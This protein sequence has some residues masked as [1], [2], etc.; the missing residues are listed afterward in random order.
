M[1]LDVHAHLYPPEYREGLRARGGASLPIAERLTRMAARDRFMDGAIDE[2]LEMMDSLGVHRQV[3]SMPNQWVLIAEPE[4]CSVHAKLAN[5]ALSEVCQ[6]YPERFRMFASLPL[7]DPAAALAELERSVT[8]HGSLGIIMPTHILGKPL[9]W[10]GLEPIWA[11]MERRQLPVF[12]HPAHPAQPVAPEGFPE[13]GMTTALFFMNEDANAITRMVLTGV[14][15]RYP[16]L[17]VICPH[18]GGAVPFLLR[19]LDLHTDPE[20]P[21]GQPLPHPPSHYINRLALGP[22]HALRL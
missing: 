22:G 14:L 19:R 15:E 21:D 8:A 6:R 18:L 3:L 16:D 5:D 13:L 12:L 2:R 9:D 11:E 4:L 1:S 20:M 17:R 10:D 7:V